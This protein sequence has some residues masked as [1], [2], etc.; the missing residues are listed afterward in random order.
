MGRSNKVSAGLMMYRLQAGMVE[1]FLIHPGGPYAAK[2]DRGVWSIPKGEIEPDEPLEET[3]VREFEEETGKPAGS[4][5][6]SLGSIRQRGGKT[7]HAWA[8]EGDWEADRELVSNTFEMEWPPRSGQ[9]QVFPE[10]DKAQFFSIAEAKEKINVR[11]VALIDR[12]LAWLSA[13]S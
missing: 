2:K 13:P 11:Q 10:V 1:V 9:M 7:V 4:P 8:F 12:L 5:R 6:I 3:A